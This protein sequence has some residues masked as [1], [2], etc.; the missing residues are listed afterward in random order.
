VVPE[1]L[2]IFFQ[3]TTYLFTADFLLCGN[4]AKQAAT[5]QPAQEEALTS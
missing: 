5:P 1:A 3:T 4:R 2:P